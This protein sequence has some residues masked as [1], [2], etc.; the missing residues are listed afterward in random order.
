M[1]LLVAGVERR[2]RKLAT[3]RVWQSHE[4]CWSQRGQTFFERAL[5]AKQRGPLGWAMGS[6][7]TC[8]ARN[9]RNNSK[10]ILRSHPSLL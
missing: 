7:L 9:S 2:V 8:A 3:K 10:V 4:C 5:Q 6:D 1:I